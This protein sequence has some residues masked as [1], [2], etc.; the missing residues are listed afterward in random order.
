MFFFVPVFVRIPL[1][2]SSKTKCLGYSVSAVHAGCG[3]EVDVIASVSVCHGEQTQF[4]EVAR[5]S[6]VL[7][8]VSDGSLAASSGGNSLRGGIMTIITCVLDPDP[9]P[10][11]ISISIHFRLN[12]FTKIQSYPFVNEAHHWCVPGAI[13]AI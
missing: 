1:L 7:L 6:S 8:I 3:L 11:S 2:L 13:P 9:P 5:L 10:C 4:T 12:N